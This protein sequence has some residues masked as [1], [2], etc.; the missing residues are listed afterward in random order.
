MNSRTLSRWVTDVRKVWGTRK[1]ESGNEVA[2]EMV[3]EVGKMASGFA[4]TK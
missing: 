2:K 4:I 3:R 1:K